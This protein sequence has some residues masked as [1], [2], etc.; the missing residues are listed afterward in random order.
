MVVASRARLQGLDP[1]AS[2]GEAETFAKTKYLKNPAR[3]AGGH[4]YVNR[5]S[6]GGLRPQGEDQHAGFVF[7]LMHEVM[8]S[9]NAQGGGCTVCDA[10]QKQPKTQGNPNPDLDEGITDLMTRALADAINHAR[11]ADAAVRG[12]I[13]P[14]VH[15]TFGNEPAV[16]YKEAVVATAKELAYPHVAQKALAHYLRGARRLSPPRT[17]VATPAGRARPAQ[18]RR[19][20]RRR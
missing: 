20:A 1:S 14:V 7:T 19:S 5:P 16:R 6:L 10:V 4:V 9:R 13:G 2:N 3:T 8:H 11:A 17:S 15:P 12:A 18:H